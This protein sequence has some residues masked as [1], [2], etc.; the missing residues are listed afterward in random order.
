MC[1]IAGIRRFGSEPITEEQVA[2]LLMAMEHRGNDATGILAQQPDGSVAT[3]KEDVPA[4]KFC[5]GATFEN[6]IGEHL[7]PDT[8]CVLLHT[9]AATQGSPRDMKNNHPLFN[10]KVGV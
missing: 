7:K 3:A 5:S 2:L 1:G 10:G 8:I 6:F 4:W 9:R